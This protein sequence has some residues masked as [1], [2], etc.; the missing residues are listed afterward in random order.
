MPYVYLIKFPY[1]KEYV[2][3]ICGS[4]QLE[5]EVNILAMFSVNDNYKIIE[6][7]IKK[8]FNSKFVLV[9]GKDFF[10]GNEKEIKI[11]FLKIVYNYE[12]GF[13][14]PKKQF[15]CEY[16]HKTFIT[17]YK[18]RRHFQSAKCI[19]NR[20]TKNSLPQNNIET[21]LSINEIESTLE[22]FM[23]EKIIRIT[24]EEY[25]LLSPSEKERKRIKINILFGWFDDYINKL[26]IKNKIRKNDD[27][28]NSIEKYLV[29]ITIDNNSY[30][31]CTHITNQDKIVDS[32]SEN[33]I[34]ETHIE[35]S[36]N[37]EL[38]ENNHIIVNNIIISQNEFNNFE[39]FNTG[40]VFDEITK[41]VI[42][43][44]NTDGTI[45]TLLS[46]Q[47]IQNVNIYKF[48]L[49]IE[50]HT[51]ILI[52][53]IEHIF[54]LE[55][56]SDYIRSSKKILHFGPKNYKD[57]VS[58]NISE[59]QMCK[60]NNENNIANSICVFCLQLCVGRYEAIQGYYKGEE[61]IKVLYSCDSCM[62]W[63]NGKIYNISSLNIPHDKTFIID[64]IH[65]MND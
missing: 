30:Y 63:E 47:D 49:G 53:K 16:C 14:E 48:K 61:N 33:I 35:S 27:F 50:F 11:E 60:Y 51:E 28:Y 59:E 12:I 57:T 10:K 34:E 2:F 42:G 4:E 19:Q 23:K 39:H 31:L 25:E 15:N 52:G 18:F 62:N 29:L 5:N 45:S 46:K 7:R 43:K 64:N 3:K 22:T 36:L 55:F 26:G 58:T 24:K 13:P 65:R 1:F 21:F 9:N 6:N 37:E 41:N 17:K 56:E 40:L 54:Y 8:S 44:Q 32:K 38:K 20:L